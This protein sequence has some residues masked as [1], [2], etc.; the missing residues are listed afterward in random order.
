[1]LLKDLGY[2]LG[3]TIVLTEDMGMRGFLKAGTTGTIVSRNLKDGYY[4]R[5]RMDIDK[6]DGR[7]HSCDRY[8]T[9]GFGFNVDP[10]KM[11]RFTNEDDFE[12]DAFE[13]IGLLGGVS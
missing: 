4:V 8:C 6:P 7:L 12:I 9:Y 10:T 11:K 2:E 5:V 13:L 3:E 1:M